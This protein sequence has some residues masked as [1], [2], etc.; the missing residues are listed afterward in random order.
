MRIRILS[1]D[2]IE[3]LYGRPHFTHEERAEYFALSVSEQAALAQFRLSN[4]KMLFVL[5]LGYFKARKMFFVFESREVEEDICFLREHYFPDTFDCALNISKVTR[6]KQ[7]RT[8]L[9]LSN[10]RSWNA[11]EQ[12]KLAARARQVAMVCSKPGYVL[13]ELMHYLTEQRVV[14]PGYS[15]MQDTV[16]GALAY[17]Q[18]R[19]AGIAYAHIDPSAKEALK[20]LLE[21]TQ[22]LHE[23]TLLKR[24]PRDFSNHEIRGEVQR[25]EQTRELYAMSQKLLPHLNISNENIRYYASLVD[26]YSVYKLRRMQESVVVVYL[27]CFIQ[28]RY[29]KLHDNLIQSLLH[30]VRRYSDE[31][32]AAA[33][34][35]V[36]NVQAATNTDLPKAGQVLKLFTDS[37]VAGSASFE[38]VR[39]KAFALLDAKRLDSVAEY[40]R[41]TA[42]FDETAFQ[43]KHLDK[44]AQRFKLPLRPILQ[45]V[46]FAATT[47]KDPLIEAICFV[48]EASRS[49]KALG[50]YKEE[51]I[52]ARWIPDKMKR[53]LYEKDEHNRKQLLPDRYE[54]LLYRHL[55]QGI[56][57]GDIFCPN[58][59][60]FRSIKDDLLNDQRWVD[61]DKLIAETGLD[62]LQQPIETHLAELKD[63][64][65]TRI[66]EVNR[67]I[68]TGENEHF[69]IKGKARWTL[70]YPS[71]SEGTNHPFF[72]QL[73]T[74]DINSVLH[75]THRQC[76]CMDAFTHVLGRY[77]KQSPDIPALIACVVAWGTNMGIGRMGQISDIG[78]H[79]LASMSDNFLRPETLREANDR[80]SN[81]TAQLPIFRHYDIGE[82][83]H[84]SSDGQKFE[85]S[86]RT[87]NARHSPKYFG[88]K[89]GI[90]PYTT[91]ANNV[92][93]NAYNIGA[94]EHESHFVFDILFNNSTDILPEIHSTD[95]HGTNEVNF[96]L[97][98]IFGYQF[99]PRYKDLYD[100]VR[101]SLTGFNQPSSYGDVTLKPVRKI[102]EA[103]IIREW[104]ECRR[105]FVSLALKET[106]QSTIVRKLSSHARNN[107]IKRALWEYDSIHRSLYLLT[108]IDSLSVRKNVQKAVNRGE[109]Y[110]QLRR[111]VSFASFGKLRFKTEYEQDLWSECSRL[112]AN[113]VIFYNASILSRFLEHQE[114]N[115]DMQ[116]ADATKKVSPIAWQNTNL[117]GRYEFQKQPDLLNVDAIIQGLLQRPA[118]R[119]AA[120]QA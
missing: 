76:Q 73:P 71:E 7:Q 103:E 108:Y 69:N 61:K 31:A 102:R 120:H 77:A 10:Y 95:T 100:K 57:A 52:P 17:E 87:F 36:Y 56:E 18:R 96:A 38:E 70:D 114:R 13:R 85:S 8:I 26:Y 2:E 53:Y 48:K 27:L 23:I 59:V 67:R 3:A 20:R 49:G 90:V 118:N 47:E 113:S 34:E 75:F 9:H 43:W 88:L 86:V 89:K 24:D 39:R 5:Q 15:A 22:G 119:V 28:H 111:A 45:G 37:S 65:E 91:V 97:L 54:F 82:V 55:R 1:D 30:H 84:S 74:T 32:K 41:T 19:L 29:Q 109:N 106:T 44:A 64:L 72:D 115:G 93:I 11:K 98:Y 58:S 16:G 78:S 60:R 80:V 105:I 117:H 46:E 81:A 33:K 4:A 112:I 116:G 63:Q 14:A 66:V 25:E 101:T 62:I 21:D 40:L 12:E 42:R 107:R 99:A 6:L 92:P 83:V 68:A 35:L 94:D 79:T 51:A 104:D 110:H 50:T